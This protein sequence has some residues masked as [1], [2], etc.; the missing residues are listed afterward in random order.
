M[1]N[2]R[3]VNELHKEA[4]EVLGSL[5]NAYDAINTKAENAYQRGLD[6]AW[7]AAIKINCLI[8]YGGLSARQ[9]L[10]IF[11]TFCESEILTKVTPSEAIAK[12]R[13]YM[14]KKEA[15][16]K[17]QVGDEVRYCASRCVIAAVEDSGCSA[18]YKS[19]HVVVIPIKYAINHKTGRHF[20]QLA[21]LLK[22]MQE[23]PKE[24]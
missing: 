1:N 12:I 10:D 20:P 11:G 17:I 24:E 18:V 5:K 9:L 2:A 21:D 15:E 23:P 7:A 14:E 4:R 19:G 6:D 3:D 22:Q 13:E 16:P 8:E